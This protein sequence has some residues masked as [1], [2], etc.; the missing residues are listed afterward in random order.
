MTIRRGL[1]KD[2]FN[3]VAVKRLSAVE[4]N[5][6]QSNQHEFNSSNQLKAMLGTP[7]RVKYK[8]QFLWL[9]GDEETISD[10]G[11]LTWYQSRKPPRSEHRLYFP[12][13]A[14]CS[15]ASEGDTLF[16]ARRT[17]DSL[18]A[19]ITPG[20]ST[21]ENQLLW[22]FGVDEQGSFSFREIDDRSLAVDFAAKRVLEELGVEIEEPEVDLLD[23][24]LAP[25]KNRFPTTAQFSELA[26]FS[27]PEVNPLDGADAALIAWLEREE[28][29]FRRL[30]RGI[31]AERLKSG[32]VSGEAQMLMASLPSL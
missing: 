9:G 13:N 25:L 31:V 5:I 7:D 19:I 4:A 8:A 27:L 32:F 6:L 17:D 1:L 24:L 10:E 30:E 21:I 16:I 11:F 23:R 15:I 22:L 29:L 12:T 14:V 2:Y 20:G 28:A 3:G 18:M 26:R